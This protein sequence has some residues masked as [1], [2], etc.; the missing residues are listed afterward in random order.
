MPHHKSFSFSFYN[1]SKIFNSKPKCK[2]M[3]IESICK[4]CGIRIGIRE[5]IANWFLLKIQDFVMI[6]TS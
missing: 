1:K 2:I 4:L 6:W 5:L 3:I